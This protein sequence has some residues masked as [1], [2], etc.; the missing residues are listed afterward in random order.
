MLRIFVFIWFAC[1]F[2]L[3][4]GC[5]HEKECGVYRLKRQVDLQN[6]NG[7]DATFSYNTDGLLEKVSGRYQRDDKFFYDNNGQ[8]IRTEAGSELDAVLLYAYDAA[9]RVIS[10][11]HDA[12]YI[13]S[14][15]FL[16]DDSN[17]IIKALFYR[18]NPEPLYYYEIEYPD[19]STVKKSV[20]LRNTDTKELELGY[21]DVYTLDNNR[22]PH[23]QEYYLY[24]FPKEEVFLPHN[25]ISV[26]T[27]YDGGRVIT[28]SFTY[29]VGGYPVSEDDIFTYE[30]SC[31]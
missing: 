23:P 17:R 9:G 19:A 27:T 14:T 16:Y 22:R 7:G 31:E 5:D 29:N 11:Y 4:L 25:A 30:Y 10:M 6:A 2:I 12:A 20:Y 18:I 28:K 24:Q 21:V 26:Q 3:L 13:D 8:L 15:V 1:F